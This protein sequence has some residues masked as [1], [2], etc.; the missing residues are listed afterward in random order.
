MTAL[1]ADGILGLIGNALQ[2]YEVSR[3][4]MRWMPDAPR[5]ICDAGFLWP[6]SLPASPGDLIDAEF[7]RVM[8][9]RFAAALRQLE[10]ALG[11][12]ADE[13]PGLAQGILALADSQVPADTSAPHVSGPTIPS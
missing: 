11:V 2:D 10:T 7:A 4:A 9:R 12:S 1:A 8:S 6:G 3:D 5:V 13:I